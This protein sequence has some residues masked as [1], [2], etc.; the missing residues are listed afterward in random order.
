MC[1]KYYNMSWLVVPE[2]EFWIVLFNDP[3][4]IF[5]TVSGILR[6]LP[7]TTVQKCQNTS[8]PVLQSS[9]FASNGVSQ[10]KQKSHH[11]SDLSSYRQVTVS[12]YV[13]SKP[14]IDTLPSAYL[15]CISYLLDPLLLIILKG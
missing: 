2:L 12:E 8:Y 3:L 9:T 13:F 1:S 11:S 15:W 6:S 14:F 10:G 5:M 7:N 4:F